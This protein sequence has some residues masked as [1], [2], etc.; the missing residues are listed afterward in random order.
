MAAILYIH[1]HCEERSDEAIHASSYVAG[2]WIASRSLSSGAHSR[3]P[4]AR[5]DVPYSWS[6]LWI[7][8]CAIAHRSSA[9]SSR[10]RS[11]WWGRDERS[12]LLGVGGGGCFRK[13]TCLG[14]CGAAPHPRPLPAAARGEGS[15]ADDAQLHIVARGSRCPQRQAL[16][17]CAGNDDTP[18]TRT[19]PAARVICPSCQRAAAR[20][21]C[22]TPQ[23][24]CIFPAIPSR[25][26]G[27]SRS[28]RTLE[29]DAVDAAV[30][31]DE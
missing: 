30:S 28:S 6:W 23:I 10:E 15:R 25:L 21:S 27:V 19:P 2:R 22:A 16:R 1:R 12:S 7:L 20:R 29:R 14:E 4:L 31:Q 9:P 3:D 8:R 11:E 17:A 5:N 26:R 18:L 13:P 24:T